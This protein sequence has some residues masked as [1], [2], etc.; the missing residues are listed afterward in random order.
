MPWLCIEKATAYSP[1]HQPAVSG[2]NSLSVDCL[3]SKLLGLR[4]PGSKQ[5]GAS[6]LPEPYSDKFQ[7][8]TLY[9]ILLTKHL[10]HILSVLWVLDEVP[11][12]D[13]FNMSM[14]LFGQVRNKFTERIIF[15]VQLL[16]MLRKWALHLNK[17]SNYF[18]PRAPK[19]GSRPGSEVGL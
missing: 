11:L 10:K 6:K 4:A 16:N 13:I 12:K 2:W 8:L 14:S 15:K 7:I 5:I 3:K 9:P 1:H 19:L 18:R 17:K